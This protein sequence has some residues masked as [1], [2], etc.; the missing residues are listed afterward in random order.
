MQQLKNPGA[1]LPL[2]AGLALLVGAARAGNITLVLALLPAVLMIAGGVRSLLFT[3]LRA[4]QLVAIGAVLGLLLALPLGLVAGVTSGLYA[5]LLSLLA[6]FATG[7]FQLSIQ[8][9]IEDVPVPAATPFYAAQVALD[10]AILGVMAVLTPASNRD[11]LGEAVAESEAAF[12]YLQAQGF[13]DDPRSYH[14]KPPPLMG[15]QITAMRVAR[16]DCELLRFSS[17][18]EPAESLPGRERWLAHG[19]NQTAQA[20]LLRHRHPGPWLVCVHGFGMGDLKKDFQTFRAAQLHQLGINLALFTLPVHG[21]RSPGRISGENFFGLSAMDFVHAESQAIW[22]LRRLIDWLRTQGA[23]RVGLHGIS[24]GGYTSALLAA[25]EPDLDCVI[26]GIPPTDMSAH[27]EYLASPLERRLAAIAGV[28]S[29]RDRAINRVVAP[30]AL[31]PMVAHSGRFIY[32]ATGD[33]FVPVEQAHALWR[34]WEKPRITWCR[35]G[36]ISVLM[37]QS[38]RQLVLDAVRE[39]LLEAPT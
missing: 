25:I 15:E 7:W 39:T 20:L 27:A 37:Q 23:S 1:W 21:A 11:A 8:P 24:L 14:H 32:A 10:Q 5:A 18:Y 36:H 22:D 16:S 31:A 28:N 33:Q 9:L 34:H 29:E 17:D 19:E 4:A 30:L 38:P 13:I 6:F 2:L 12:D 35:A 26:A 3:D